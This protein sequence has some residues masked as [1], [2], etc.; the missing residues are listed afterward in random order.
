VDNKVRLELTNNG[1]VARITL[2]APKANI[3]DK[4]MMLG[5]GAALD[6][7]AVQKNLK[8]IVLAGAGAHFSFGASIEEHLPDR[9]G[10]TLM[11]LRNLLLKMAAAPAPMIAAVRGQCLGGGF[12]LA[13]ACDL[14][15]AE[16]SAQFGLPEI[17]LGVFPPAG[18]AL[19][20]M[21]VGS[22]SAAEMVL[23]G[24]SWTA[25]QAAATGLVSK[26]FFSGDLETQLGAW[27]QSDFLPRSAAA[28][29]FAAQ[30]SRRPLVRALEVDLPALE[31]LY[32]DQL[33]AQPDAVE[34]VLAFLEKRQPHW[35]ADQMIA[36]TPCEK[37]AVTG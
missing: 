37:D 17:K 27:L 1:Q 28:L 13:L 33:M 12:E 16:D 31:R 11:H 30:A 19:L 14:I 21:R 7:L 4:A 26:V 9:I 20:P 29:C 5:I 23:T 15:V 22:G 10:D 36:G 25:N 24:A 3:L 34:G 35:L 8:A 32:L 2:A 18:A 6:E